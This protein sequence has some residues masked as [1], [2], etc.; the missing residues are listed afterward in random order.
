MLNTKPVRHNVPTVSLAQPIV[1][2]E[3][4]VQKQYTMIY[5]ICV[6]V[7]LH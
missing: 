5:D 6:T 4:E 2:N 3:H 7:T 1:L